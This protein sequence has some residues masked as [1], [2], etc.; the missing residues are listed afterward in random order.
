MGA[1][2]IR[3]TEE[4]ESRLLH[5]AN[6]ENRPRSEVVRRAIDEYLRRREHERFMENL[7]REARTAY[8][9][10]AIR[11]ESRELNEETSPAE[12]EAL[13]HAEGRGEED[14]EQWWR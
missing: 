12:N 11:G 5:E 1:I 9:N 7:V 3:L 6:L 10:P 14:T 8:A 13:R 2:S 4:I